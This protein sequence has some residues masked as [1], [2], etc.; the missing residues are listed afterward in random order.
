MRLTDIT[1]SSPVPQKYFKSFLAGWIILIILV[2]AYQQWRLK[3]DWLHVPGSE[4]EW[5][6][7]SI[8]GGHGYSFPGIN[9]WLYPETTDN[10]YYSTAWTEP[11]YTLFMAFCF[12]VFKDY[13]S[14]A[15]LLFQS[16]SLVLTSITILYLGSQV[17]NVWTGL[18]ASLSLPLLS[19]VSN[20][21]Q[22]SLGNFALAGLLTSLSACLI[23]Y[24]LRR[25]SLRRSVLLGIF[26]GF[27]TLT[28]SAIAAFIPIAMLLIWTSRHPI[29]TEKWVAALAVPVVSIA[30]ISPWVVRNL[31]TFDAFVPLRNGFGFNAY[32]GNPALAETYGSP[33]KDCPP[34]TAPAFRSSSPWDA[35]MLTLNIDNQRALYERA[36]QCMASSAPQGYS[37]LNEAQRDRLYLMRVFSFIRSEPV[38]WIQITW[39]KILLFF[40]SHFVQ[41][42]ISLLAFFGLII[43]RKKSHARLIGLLILGFA[44][45]YILAIPF[46]YRYRYPIEPLILVLASYTIYM[47][48]RIG[49]K[50]V[51]RGIQSFQ[52]GSE[53]SA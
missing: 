21:N 37:Q 49:I 38:Q 22:A 46:Y 10:G 2:T 6:S 36:Y 16:L 12:K 53:I 45:P 52:Q 35:V 50:L 24:T 31:L 27:A 13:G 51:A 26:L 34:G 29:R 43:S 33:G 15:I 30:I 4:F 28:H 11:V 47:G 48:S 19:S 32:I 3:V 9:R 23:L 7:E 41:L 20:L 8:A 44:A 42:I 18:L 39:Y 17:F 1:E 40:G 25:I 5:V 14:I